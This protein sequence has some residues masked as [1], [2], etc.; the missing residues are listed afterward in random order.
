MRRALTFV[1]AAAVASCSPGGHFIIVNIHNLPAATTGLYAR[2][3]LDQQPAQIVEQ[4]AAPSDGFGSDSSF[5]LELPNDVTGRLSVSVEAWIDKCAAASRSADVVLVSGEL[6]VELSL[7]AIDPQDCSGNFVHPPDMVRVPGVRFTM[8]CNSAAD[9]SCETDEQ[10]THLVTLPSY[11]IDRTEVSR[12]AYRSCQ[13]HS[14]VCTPALIDQPASTAAEAFIPWDGAD[15]YCR[16]RGKR[17]PTE[18]EWELA[19]RGTDGRIYPWGNDAPTCS[20]ANYEPVA[21]N[22]PC[23]AVN[24][25]F[26]GPID[27][28]GGVSPYGALG[29]AG[30]VQEWVADWYASA[31]SAAPVTNPTGPASGIHRVLRGGSWIS[32]AAELRA[33]RRNA[34]A[35][36]ATDASG[37]LTKEANSTTMGI[38]CARSQ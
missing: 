10:P 21:G 12:A 32:Q 36:D 29:M 17:L 16:A 23:Y 38:R 15:A 30:N 2:S 20:L 35:P 3:A 25:D 28:F 34:N 14:S 19:A 4:F 8:G 26:V 1:L 7:D 37:Q 22:N 18:A 5:A 27:A 11:F 31:Y 24:S 33:S 13:A 9:P 6:T